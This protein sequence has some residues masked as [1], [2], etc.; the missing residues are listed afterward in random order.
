MAC[1]FAN[2]LDRLPASSALAVGTFDGVH[3]GHQALI[4]AMRDFAESTHRTPC[5][6]TFSNSPNALLAPNRVPGRILQEQAFLR[7]LS[8]LLPDGTLLCVPFDHALADLSAQDFANRLR[9]TTIFCGEDWRFGAGAEG[10]PDFLKAQGFDVRV[11]PYATWQGERVSSTRIRASMASGRLDAVSAM[12]SRP[13]SFEGRVIHG[14]QLARELLGIPTA[15]IPYVASPDEAPLAPLARG[16]YSAIAT[17]PTSS[18]PA[19][20]NFG[21]APSI[22]NESTP[23]FEA[24]LLDITEDLYDSPVRLSFTS[25]QIRPEVKFSSV[26]ALKAQVLEDLKRV[27]EDVTRP[28]ASLK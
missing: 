24:Y 1:L 4:R 22:K 25:A 7:E 12:L 3:V 9:G 20:V 26:D 18:H 6:L 28:S 13:W 14:R 17:T 2:S 10:T 15:N 21:V 27:R 23:L 19:L 16:V 8:A 11:V 5:I